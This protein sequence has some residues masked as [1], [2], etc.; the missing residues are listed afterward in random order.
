[1]GVVWC[2]VA[3]VWCD[4]MLCGV[5]LCYVMWCDV[6]WCDVANYLGTRHIGGPQSSR[7]LSIMR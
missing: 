7:Y 4:V 6:M 2:V 3:V 1:M 5:I